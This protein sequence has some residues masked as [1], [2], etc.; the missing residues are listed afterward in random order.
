MPVP[1]LGGNRTA[2]ISL[3]YATNQIGAAAASALDCHEMETPEYYRQKADAAELAGEAATDAEA[4]RMY[5]A[6]ARRWRELANIAQGISDEQ[7]K[8]L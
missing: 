3:W 6:A 4:K 7:R 1:T 2:A 8:R 5:P